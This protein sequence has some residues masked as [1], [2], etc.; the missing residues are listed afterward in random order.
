MFKIEKKGNVIYSYA[1]GKL[2]NDDYDRMIPMVKKAI[3]KHG[4]I[5]WYFQVDKFEG[6]TPESFWREVKFDAKHRHDLEKAAI[7]GQEKW[8]DWMTQVMKPFTSADVRYFDETEKDEA[9]NWIR[10]GAPKTSSP[11]RKKAHTY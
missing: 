9:M 11:Q 5:R 7:V 1:S 10:Y 8:H 2:N 4:K 6:W 3:E